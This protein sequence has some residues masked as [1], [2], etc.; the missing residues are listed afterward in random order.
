[1]FC[2]TRGLSIDNTN[3]LSTR[4]FQACLDMQD[5]T[6]GLCK[7][8][9][10]KDFIDC[11]KQNSSINH[12]NALVCHQPDHSPRSEGSILLQGH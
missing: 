11:T 7:T 8:K 3:I 9:K 4:H 12:E 1:M 10:F 5:T 2:S 6:V